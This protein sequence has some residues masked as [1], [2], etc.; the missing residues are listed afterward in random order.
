MNVN[1]EDILRILRDAGPDGILAPDIARKFDGPGND[2]QRRNSRVNAS[3]GDLRR[4]GYARRSAGKEPSHVYHN[5]PTWRWYGTRE[6]GLYLD[7]GCYD[8]QVQRSRLAAAAAGAEYARGRAVA[9]ARR[10]YRAALLASVPVPPPVH[11]CQRDAEIRH[12]H[13]ENCIL[14][15]I[16]KLFDLTRERV[17]QI[18]CGHKT[19]PCD[20][21]GH[22]Y[23]M[24]SC[25]HGVVVR[26]PDPG[27]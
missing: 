7:G 9:A 12:L 1:V 24:T 5:V 6:G 21:Y 20:V 14:D 23:V 13:Q 10:E 17:R 22:D 11:K 15:D 18:C 4:R 26:P 25:S 19:S 27:A 16:G 3:L 8:G 2:T